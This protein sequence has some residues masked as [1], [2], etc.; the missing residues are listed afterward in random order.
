VLIVRAR[1]PMEERG[2]RR[3]V[4]SDRFFSYYP[5]QEI[6]DTYCIECPEN[7]GEGEP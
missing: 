6:L 5:E 7:R 1:L 4:E 2:V 3:S